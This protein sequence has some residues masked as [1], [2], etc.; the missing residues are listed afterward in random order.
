[1]SQHGSLIALSANTDCCASN[2][3]EIELKELGPEPSRA[4]DSSYLALVA[5]WPTKFTQPD[6]K[7]PR[8]QHTCK[9]RCEEVA[10]MSVLRQSLAHEG[11]LWAITSLGLHLPK[12]LRNCTILEKLMPFCSMPTDHMREEQGQE[13]EMA[14][15]VLQPIQA[16]HTNLIK[17]FQ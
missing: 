12:F 16:A 9:H 17:T 14:S 2:L 1:M 3:K 5:Y 6:T 10:Q 13:V 7:T 4:L 15:A 11:E 8:L